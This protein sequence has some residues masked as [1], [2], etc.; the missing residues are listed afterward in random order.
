M[1][2]TGTSWHAVNQLRYFR[3]YHPL[4]IPDFPGTTTRQGVES[5]QLTR[6]LNGPVS[7]SDNFVLDQLQGAG[8][9]LVISTNWSNSI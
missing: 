9:H 1:V 5:Y 3:H 6:H 4:S 8:K 2:V 7:A